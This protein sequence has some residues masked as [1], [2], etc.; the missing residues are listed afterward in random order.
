MPVLQKFR[1]D[2]LSRTGFSTLR[3][4]WELGCPIEMHPNTSL[5]SRQDDE[6][7][8]DRTKTEAAYAKAFLELFTDLELPQEVAVHCG[9]QFGATRERLLRRPREDYERYRQ[10]L[11]ETDLPDYLSGRILEYSWHM[12]LGAPAV[13]CPE[14]EQCFCDKFG[15]CDLKDCA[16]H[17]CPNPWHF[18]YGVLPKGWPEEG[19]G[20]DGWVAR[21]W[22]DWGPNGL[23]EQ[24]KNPV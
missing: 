13:Y 17:G 2:H 12:I 4:T 21:D 7:A 15:L 10:W 14:A 16:V 23:R 5:P 19:P 6:E 1:I 22:A 8:D 24:S 3:C 9:A 20:Q 18:K 11:L